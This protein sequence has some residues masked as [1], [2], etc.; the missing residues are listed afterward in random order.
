MLATFL[1]AWQTSLPSSLTRFHGQGPQLLH[2]LD[3]TLRGG[4]Q[5]NGHRAHDA[6]DAAEHPEGMQLFL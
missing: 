5:H 2:R 3:V 4:V 6:E 1:H